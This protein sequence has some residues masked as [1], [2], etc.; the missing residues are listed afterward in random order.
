LENFR[1]QMNSEQ[2]TSPPS[3]HWKWLIKDF[4][5]TLIISVLVFLG[6]NA[7]TARIRVESISMQETLLAGDFVLV[8]KLAYFSDVPKRGDIVVFTPPFEAPEPYIKRIIGLPGDIVKI[9]NGKVL[10]N[11]KQIQEPY[12][13]SPQGSPGKWLVPDNAIFVMGDN[14]VSSSDSRSWGTVPIENLIGEAIFVYWPPDQWG[15]LTRSAI[16][17]EAQQ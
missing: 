4:F 9:Y 7:V 12:I 17:A 16:A 6:I 3:I 1:S 2:K 15:A 11:D 14:R 10:V 8:N 5:Q 13:D